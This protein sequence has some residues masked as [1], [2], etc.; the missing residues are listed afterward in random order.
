MYFYFDT[1]F[2]EPEDNPKNIQLVS[3][4]VVSSEGLCFY[5]ESNEY[6]A[7]LASDWVQKHVLSQLGST[8]GESNKVI[9]NELKLWVNSICKSKYPTFWGWFA[10]WDWML[11]CNLFGGMMK[12]PSGW[13]QLCLDVKQ[14]HRRLGG[15][16]TIPEQLSTEHHALNDALWT[17][18]VHEYLRNYERQLTP[19]QLHF[20]EQ[21]WTQIK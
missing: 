20:N 17:K 19:E 9:A 14:E 1:E 18:D 13:P 15:M 10:D 3:I 8:K 21:Y 4:G 2:I 16:R 7:S 5:A 6:D 12:L 11:L